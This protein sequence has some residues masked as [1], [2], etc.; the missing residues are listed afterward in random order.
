MSFKVTNNNISFDCKLW[1]NKSKI[2][3]QNIIENE[4]KLCKIEGYLNCEYYYGHKYILNVNNIVL[5]NENSRL[6]LLK[7]EILKK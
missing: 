2:S 7:E 5:E 1:T 3:I 4:N 6:K